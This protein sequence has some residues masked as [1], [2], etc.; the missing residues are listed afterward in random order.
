MFLN[1][2]FQ[3]FC[4]INQKLLNVTR[5]MYHLLEL[6]FEKSNKNDKFLFKFNIVD[7]NNNVKISFNVF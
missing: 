6:K 1:E 3:C 7:D 4:E 5:H 2:C